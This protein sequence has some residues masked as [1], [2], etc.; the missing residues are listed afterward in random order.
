MVGVD[1]SQAMLAEARARLRDANLPIELRVG[2]A[3][4]LDFASDTFDGC[5]A[6]RRR[7]VA[8]RRGGCDLNLEYHNLAEQDFSW[9]E[10]WRLNLNALEASFLDES[11]RAAYRKEWA[12]WRKLNDC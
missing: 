5:R 2:N 12:E 3:E 11:Q 1:G 10:L 8:D 9:D 7:T 4:Q 6:E